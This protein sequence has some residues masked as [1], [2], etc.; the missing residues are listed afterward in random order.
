MFLWPAQSM[1]N[2]EADPA[3]ATK[4][5]NLLLVPAKAAAIC[6][7]HSANAWPGSPGLPP[8][9]Q[10]AHRLVPGFAV[11]PAP[12]D[13]VRQESVPLS[14]SCFWPVQPP[15]GQR[16]TFGAGNPGQPV[17]VKPLV[18]IDD[19]AFSGHRRA[20][21]FLDQLIGPFIVR[22]VGITEEIHL[23][24]QL[25]LQTSAAFRDFQ[26][27]F[28]SAES[29]QDR[30]AQRMRSH[31]DEIVIK[32]PQAIPIHDVKSFALNGR[33]LKAGSGLSDSCF[34]HAAL[35]E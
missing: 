2:C 25:L 5:R 30:M 22:A 15:C 33:R 27:H 13:Y 24:L 11:F 9:D 14:C 7:K 31:S 3:P 8:Q 20:I 16:G 35:L 26:F 21:R 12:R 1:C 34:N 17:K 10:F 28:I 4:P 19:A 18:A 32:G 29:G 6:A 23:P